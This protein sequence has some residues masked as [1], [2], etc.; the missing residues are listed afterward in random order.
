MR[1][2]SL[3]VRRAGGLVIPNGPDRAGT[4]A[5]LYAGQELPAVQV[6]LMD[7]PARVHFAPKA[8]AGAISS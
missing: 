3:G 2:A 4:I 6:Q 5:E 1:Q 7:D 8:V